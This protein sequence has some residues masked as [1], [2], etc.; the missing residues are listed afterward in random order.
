MP[1]DIVQALR[2][3]RELF[4]DGKHRLG[5]LVM[6]PELIDEASDYDERLGGK[7]LKA[8]DRCTPHPFTFLLFCDGAKAIA[9]GDH[10]GFVYDYD[11]KPEE[12]TAVIGA[13]C[14]KATRGGA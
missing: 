11:R 1:A 13:A 9:N 10:T 4:L 5:G 2:R 14:V 8:L 7:M 12:I 3:A 6:W